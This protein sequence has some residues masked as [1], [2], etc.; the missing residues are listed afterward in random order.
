MAAKSIPYLLTTSNNYQNNHN[1]ILKYF[2]WN[3]H[4][5]S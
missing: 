4:Q 1:D 2:E 3:S 5:Q